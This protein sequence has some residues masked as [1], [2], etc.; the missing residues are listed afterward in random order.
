MCLN[1]QIFIFDRLFD[2]RFPLLR[3]CL[4]KPID[5]EIRCFKHFNKLQYM[6]VFVNRIIE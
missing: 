5:Y 1:Y 4:Y 2:E 3:F 6:Y